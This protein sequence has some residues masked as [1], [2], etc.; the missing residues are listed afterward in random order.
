MVVIHYHMFVSVTVGSRRQW[1]MYNTLEVDALHLITH[2]YQLTLRYE[3]ASV[4][5]FLTPPRYKTIHD[6]RLISYL[7]GVVNWCSY[8]LHMYYVNKNVA[9]LILK[10]MKRKAE[11]EP[12]NKV[13]YYYKQ[14]NVHL[15]TIYIQCYPNFWKKNPE[16]SKKNRHTKKK[17]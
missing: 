2:T 12:L 14:Q 9:N 7:L 8:I 15:K 6:G 17:G 11:Q 3:V 5:Y 10:G 16:Q 1:L 13:F 4:C